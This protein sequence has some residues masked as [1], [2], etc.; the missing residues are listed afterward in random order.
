MRPYHSVSLRLK[1]GLDLALVRAL[2]R[3]LRALGYLGKGIDGDFGQGTERAVRA[4]QY[5]L[6]HHAGGN[7][8]PLAIREYC[9]GRV[10]AVTGVVESGLAACIDDM[11]NATAFVKVPSS[12][13]PSDD[14]KRALDAVRAMTNLAVPKPFLLAVLGQESNW[15]HFAVPKPANEDNFVTLGLDRNDKANP[16]HI[17]SRGYGMGQYTFS[18]HPLTVDEMRTYVMDPVQNVRKAVD[19][20]L[21]KFNGFIIGRS[22]GK[23]ADDR[24]R[25]VDGPGATAFKPLRR[26]RYDEGDARYM[27]DCKACM[28]AAGTQTVKTGDPVYLGARTKYAP[29]QYH[30]ETKY[31]GVPVRKNIPCDWS[32]AI[33]RYNGGGVNSYHYQT[34]V[35]LRVLREG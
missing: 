1:A 12:A 8:A 16:D 29:T 34:Q 25:E 7:G 26:C 2:Q 10:T 31:E 18:H 20:L 22:S 9:G 4:L 13:T 33:R 24:I 27:N 17:T 35:L 6:L 28:Q 32:Y 21:E 14:N 19:E 5:D 3:D 11:I 23:R 15:R 30:P